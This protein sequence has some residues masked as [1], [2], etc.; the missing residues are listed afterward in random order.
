MRGLDHD[1]IVRLLEFSES[2]D[3]YYLVL[4]LVQG[5]ELFHQI[6]K[7]TYFSEPLARHVIVQVAEAIQYMHESAGVVHRDIKPENILFEP[8]PIIPS[9]E[10]II[11]PYDEE[12]ADEGE[13]TPGVGG[14]GI[15][16]VKIAD[17]GLSKIV[18]ES[19][20]KTPCG[21]AGYTAPEIVKDQRYNKSVDMWALG[22][23]LY[24]ILVG[25]PPFFHEDIA[26]LTQ[27]VAKGEYTFLSPWWDDISASAKDL[28]THLLTVDPRQ[29]YTIDQFLAHPWIQAGSL[30]ESS[31]P[32]VVTKTHLQPTVARTPPLDSPLLYA[33]RGDDQDTR[34]AR[35]AMGL[36]TP[37]VQQLREAF[38][39]SYAVHRIEEEAYHRNALAAGSTAAPGLMQLN[40]EDE[41]EENPRLP[42]A[43]NA[44]LAQRRQ[45][46]QA[47]AE[48]A[49]APARASGGARRAPPLPTLAL[50]PKKRGGFE[51]NMNNATLLRNRG[52][53][54][55]KLPQKNFLSPTAAQ[56]AVSPVPSPVI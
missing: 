1:N 3:Y 30:P 25:F 6:A 33:L 8:I 31:A 53:R 52:N 14:G 49:Y 41:G 51:L 32:P 40:E 11:R 37:G 5:G 42:P 38:D 10:P 15:G 12:K 44:A 4:E 23:V 20:T 39:V 2:N 56:A 50:P 36:T 54:E 21:T 46:R 9:K 19:S 47:E 22:C 24:T 28:I 55:R 43:V 35:A 48:P 16:R 13:F 29:R 18:W 45:D 7:L 17:F 27:K 34:H 26:T